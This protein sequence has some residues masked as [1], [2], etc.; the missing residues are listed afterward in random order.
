MVAGLVDEDFATHC[1]LGSVRDGVLTVLV[2]DES[3]VYAYRVRWTLEILDGIRAA[4]PRSRIRR[5]RFVK[6]DPAS[7]AASGR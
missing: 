4:C 2:R 6:G 7:G 3:L 5:V 1:S